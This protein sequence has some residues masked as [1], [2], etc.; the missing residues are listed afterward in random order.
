MNLR[1]LFVCAGIFWGS[2]LVAQITDVV[3]D[4][5]E[6]DASWFQRHYFHN[7]G[8]TVLID[9]FSPPVMVI[10]NVRETVHGLDTNITVRN[11]WGFNLLTVTYEARL[12]II[13]L[14]DRASISLNVPVSLGLGYIEPGGILTLSNP[15]LVD[16]NYGCHS[17]Y[18]NIN[19]FGFHVGGGAN[20]M[21]AP[22]IGLDATEINRF[23]IAPMVRVGVKGPYKH[24]NCFGY[25]Q[26][27]I[28]DYYVHPETGKRYKH[29]EH[30]KIVVGLL[31]NYD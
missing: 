25:V 29:R 2:N 15:V 27:N 24:Y 10:N 5:K 20:M 16:F 12:N 9:Y 28:P 19:K 17:T 4:Q 31:L 21:L 22:I 1:H 7:I 26:M 23:W 30:F 6:Y 3:Q 8:F 18:N 14:N 13:D 11:N